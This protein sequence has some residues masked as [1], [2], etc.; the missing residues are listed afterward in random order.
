MKRRH[1][2]LLNVFGHDQIR[3]MSVSYEFSNSLANRTAGFVS[4]CGTDIQTAS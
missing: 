4:N 1:L 3:G 2:F